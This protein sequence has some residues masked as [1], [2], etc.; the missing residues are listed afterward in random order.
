MPSHRCPAALA[1]LALPLVCGSAAAQPQVRVILIEDTPISPGSATVYSS[2]GSP[3]LGGPTTVYFTAGTGTNPNSSGT[4]GIYRWDETTEQI[5]LIAQVG[6][7]APQAASATLGSLGALNAS[8]ND[9]VCFV[10]GL[11]GPGV[12][13]S[14]VS[15]IYRGGPSGLSLI[16][17]QSD[18]L[19]GLDGPIITGAIG[20]DSLAPA[21][22]FSPTGQAAFA[23]SGNST[24]GVF[25]AGSG[26]PGYA[27]ATTYPAPGPAGTL[28]NSLISFSPLIN[29]HGDVLTAANIRGGTPPVTRGAIIRLRADGARESILEGM[30]SVN[31]VAAGFNDAG[32][33]ALLLGLTGM[34]IGLYRLSAQGTPDLIAGQND[35]A[36]GVDTGATYQSILRTVIDPDGRALFVAV[37]AGPTVTTANRTVICRGVPGSVQLIARDGDFAPGGGGARFTFGTTSQF[38]PS[39]GA[40][41]RVMFT[42]GLVGGVSGAW[43]TDCDGALQPLLLTGQS[44]QLPDG[45][46]AVV[47]AISL[48]PSLLAT[49][50]Q[51]GRV[52]VFDGSGRYVARVRLGNGPFAIVQVILP[53]DPAPDCPA[54]F[55]NSGSVTL[56]DLFDFLGAWF[57]LDSAAD[58]NAQNGVTLQ[59]LFDYLGAFFEPC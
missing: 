8:R 18:P 59:D 25:R 29:G 35:P 57:A 55:D 53:C 23:A 34:P 24:T 45:S 54:D 32:Q 9:E 28:F 58:F 12:T 30:T 47:T 21:S 15:T 33:S 14:D 1:L 17:R 42:S 22:L 40:N 16:V 26:T 36:I 27:A 41:G 20:P 38:L 19:P 3:V 5:T 56:Q 48:Q 11:T 46:S 10:A 51:D 39:T 4:A 6:Q 52:R 49:G 43:A 37:L 50:G 2:V 44:I 7:T 31:P 13:F